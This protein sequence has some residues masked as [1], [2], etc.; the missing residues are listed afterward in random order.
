LGNVS[1]SKTTSLYEEN[2]M[3]N[4]KIFRIY[5]LKVQDPEGGIV[6]YFGTTMFRLYAESED[7]ACD[8]FL[9]EYD[10]LQDDFD[11]NE[12]REI[13][14]DEIDALSIGK[15]DIDSSPAVNRLM[16]RLE[17]HLRS[18]FFEESDASELDLGSLGI[19]Y[20]L[21]TADVAWIRAWSPQ[22]LVVETHADMD[23]FS[24]EDLSPNQAAD[25]YV[26]DCWEVCS[27]QWQE[28]EDYELLE[29]C[30]PRLTPS[31][32]SNVRASLTAQVESLQTRR[33]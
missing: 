26:S 19:N 5:E 14:F 31:G 16:S 25:D 18:C 11:P 28:L 24:E 23:W 13:Y 27:D 15:G 12:I 22:E 29:G 9:D 33:V 20:E 4:N 32:M 8:M 3:T 7:E 21:T 1:P 6:D 2:K 30:S 10:L 17:S